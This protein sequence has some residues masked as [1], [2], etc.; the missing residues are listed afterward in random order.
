MRV[1]EL[2]T[3]T[4]E[5]GYRDHRVSAT[6]I[7]SFATETQTAF[8]PSE[9]SP[10][11]AAKPRRGGRREPENEKPIAHELFVFWLPSSS[12]PAALRPAAGP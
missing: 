12:Q 1:K 3:V 7:L 4:T 8:E 10:A 11:V 2:A 5:F 9:A 6:E